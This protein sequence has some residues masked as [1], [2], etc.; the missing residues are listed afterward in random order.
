MISRDLVTQA[1]TEII[2]PEL[3]ELSA[4]VDT[5]PNSI[6]IKGSPEVK[7]IAV[8]V[9]CSTE[10]LKKAIQAGATYV[11]CHHG[12][13]ASDYIINGRFNAI[14]ERLKLIIKNDITL[15]G[16]HYSLDA[17]PDIGNNAVL[18]KRL[19]AVKTDESYF[20]GWGWVGEYEKP[21][22]IDELIRRCEVICKHPVFAVKTGSKKIKRIG[23]CSGGARPHGDELMD[24]VDKHIDAHITGEIS[25]SGPYIAEELKFNYLSC[26]HYSTET[27]GVQALTQKLVE[28]FGIDVQVKFIDVPS[29]L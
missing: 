15:A 4:K 20:D 11:I 9:S 19:F 7:T 25:E 12:L 2:G 14:E 16:F 18:I 22:L 3:L 13:G 17:H 28:R 6:Q 27:F 23:V 8:G 5:R 24:I 26:G 10:F 29:T 1:L 21:I